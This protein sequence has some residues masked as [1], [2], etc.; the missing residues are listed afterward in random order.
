VIDSTLILTALLLL[1]G[2][3]V[4]GYL[5]GRA[6]DRVLL[7]FAGYHV[8]LERTDGRLVWGQLALHTTGMELVYRGDVQDEHH[9]ETS[10]ILY[11]DEYPKIQAIYRYCDHMEDDQSQRRQ[12]DLDRSFHPTLRRR[13]LRR[14]RNMLGEMLDSVGQAIGIL[15]G[16]LHSRSTKGVI[17]SG[18]DYIASV[19]QNIVGY[20]GTRYD[21]LLEHYVGARVVVEVTEGNVVY[22]HVGVLKDYTADFLEILDVHYPNQSAVQL[23]GEHDCSEDSHLCLR[24][25]GDMLYVSNSGDYSLFLQRLRVGDQVKPLQAVLDRDDEMELHLAPDTPADAIVE[26]SVKIVRHL[27]WIVPRAHAVIRHKAEHYDPDQVFDIG[28]VLNLDR[29]TKAEEQYMRLLAEKPDNAPCALELGQILF[30][31]GA[32]D[33]A[34]QWFQHALKYRHNLLDGGKL[35]D[36]QLIYIRRK[37]ARR[38]KAA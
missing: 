1:G 36:R 22:E 25:E 23:K 32:M 31:R 11:R 6:R 5:K 3:L 30:Q 26:I 38:R 2:A 28:F 12:R 29:Y 34:E 8:T 9:I 17:S 33:D 4:S 27:D 10:Y 20:A 37:R 24:R 14:G 21:P 35:A 13:L 18:D 15:A 19:G 16:H 7:D